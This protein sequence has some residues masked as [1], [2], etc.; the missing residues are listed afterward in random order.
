MIPLGL[1]PQVASRFLFEVEGVEIGVFKEV[2]G[3]QMTVD[4]VS[5]VE[6]GQNGFVH[7]LPGRM[8][9]SNI[10]FKRG[11]MHGDALFDWVS[12]TSG[13]GFAG[14]RN[15]L[16]RQWAAITAINSWGI[17]LRDWTLRDAFP[18]RWK[19]PDFSIENRNSLDEEL[20]ITHHGFTS[21]TFT[22]LP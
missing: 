19:G 10:I 8:T 16:D 21:K 13:S 2:T 9:W 5:V 11:L 15:S 1:E 14:K 3:L 12:E 20:E 6:G 18:V 7:K 22:P 4:P 17:P